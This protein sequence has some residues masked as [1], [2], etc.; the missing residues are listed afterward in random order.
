MKSWLLYKYK[1][2]LV[3]D[4]LQCTNK[5]TNRLLKLVQ[6]RIWLTEINILYWTK[7]IFLAM[8]KN[9]L[10]CPQ[11]YTIYPLLLNN[12]KWS[13]QQKVIQR[14]RMSYSLLCPFLSAL[15]FILAASSIVSHEFWG[16]IKNFQLKKC[17][18]Y[19]NQ[20]VSCTQKH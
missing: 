11:F 12:L 16:N 7:F 20:N 1:K 8:V 10:H 2:K 13:G 6:M 19:Q 14:I 15:Q 17:T 5:K 18:L 4:F 9:H 3:K